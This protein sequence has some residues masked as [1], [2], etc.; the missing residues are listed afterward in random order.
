MNSEGSVDFKN[1]PLT[2]TYLKF[3]LDRLTQYQDIDEK[4]KLSD[5]E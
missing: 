2:N 1:A 3:R 5:R 4:S